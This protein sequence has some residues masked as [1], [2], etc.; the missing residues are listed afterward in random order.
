MTPGIPSPPSAEPGGLRRRAIHGT[1]WFGGSRV[2]TQAIGWLITLVVV[3]LLTPADYGLFGYAT[4]VAGFTDLVAE[5][6]LGAAIVQ[7]RDLDETEIESAFWLSMATAATLYGVIWLFAPAL[8]AFFNQPQ[9]IDVLRV[10]MLTFVIT[11]IRVISSNLLT[12]QVDFK[13]RAMGDMAGTLAGSFTTLA[14]AYAGDGVWALVFGQL[15]RQ[16][17]VTLAFVAMWPWRPRGRFS[18]E[19]ARKVFGFGLRTSGGRIAWYLYSNADYLVVGK[20]VGQQA[21]GFYTL[22]YEFATLPAGRVTTVINEVA[23][24]VYAQLQDR[25]EQFKRYFLTAVTL[26]SAITVPAL[27]G[28]LATAPLAVPVIL[29][30]KWLPIVEPLQIMSVVGMVLSVSSLIA[31][32]VLAKGRPGLVLRF[33][34]TCL[35]VM[36]AG[37]L[38]GSRFGLLGVCWAWLILFPAVTMM[39]FSMTRS[40][41]GYRWGELASALLPASVS[42]VTM[43]L[44]LALVRPAT[45]FL[46][47]GPV[48]LAVVV[49]AGAATYGLAMGIGFRGRVREMRAAIMNRG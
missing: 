44:A 26:V 42:A 12:K 29:T 38:I 27:F 43:A 34:L 24:P 11:S 17:V 7:K 45:E 47:L 22:V 39:W 41:I 5:L 31:P 30:A 35:A 28:L 13:R 25:P 10:S 37:F 3:R 6:G 2:F 21:L 32:A 4:L 23:F 46:P 19:G 15:V 1:M 9:L 40:L 18:R 48:R 33:N 8:S 20:F 49:A 16:S 36:P 14:L